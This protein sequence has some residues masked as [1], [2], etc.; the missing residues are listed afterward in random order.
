MTTLAALLI[1]FGALLLGAPLLTGAVDLSSGQAVV[2]AVLL[3]GG[4]V[5]LAVQSRSS[6]R[7]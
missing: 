7:R 6:V 4:C 1:G 5:M 3:V 2:G